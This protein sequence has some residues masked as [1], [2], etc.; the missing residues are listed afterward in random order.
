MMRKHDP[1]IGLDPTDGETRHRQGLR[2]ARH[3]KEVEVLRRADEGILVP[4]ES[5][6][7]AEVRNPDHQDTIGMDKPPGMREP[8]NG[9]NRMFEHLT[10][11]NDAEWISPFEL[12]ERTASA[13]CIRDAR[14]EVTHLWRQVKQNGR[15]PRLREC[16]GEAAVPGTDIER[17]A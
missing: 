4:Q 9:I 17:K 6:N 10:H 2:E 13:Y 16:V 7:A 1:T 15:G 11:R 3:R 12:L 8:T 5:I 14:R